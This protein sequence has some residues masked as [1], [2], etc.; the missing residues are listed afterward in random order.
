MSTGVSRRSY[1]KYAGATVVLGAVA[2]ASYGVYEMSKP[3]VTPSP[4][5]TQTPTPTPTP[6][7]MKPSI[8]VYAYATKDVV[9]FWDPSENSAHSNEVVVMNNVYEQLVRY[10]PVQ[11]KYV[12]VLSSG[13]KVSE[14]GL[15]YDF[16]L[17][18]GVKFHCG[19]YFD[20]YSVKYSIERNLKGW[21]GGGP[22]G[23]SYI[24]KLV[25]EISVIDDHT[26][27]FELQYPAA[28]L[29]IA[30]APY[31]A[32]M[33]CPKCTEQ[34][35]HEWFYEGHDLGTGPYV[36]EKW[37]K[38][39]D[40]VT[41]LKFEDYWGGWSGKHFDK[42]VIK[43][44][45]EWAEARLE[46]EAGDADIVDR[47]PFEDIEALEKVQGV[48]V[49][50]TAAYQNMLGF[51]NTKKPP[52]DDKLVRQAISYAVPYQDIVNYA[53]HGNARQSKGPVPYGMWGHGEEVFQ[54]AYDLAKAK[55]LLAK[56]GRP[57]GGFSLLYTYNAGDEYERRS[58]ELLKAELEK[59]GITLELKGM[60]WEEQWALAQAEKPKDRQ[61]IFVMYWWS[62]Y[63]DPYTFLEP[64]FHSEEAI[65]FNLG[66]YSN[67]EYDKLIE[68]GSAIAGKDRVKALSMYIEAQQKLVED[69]PS[70]FFFD[71][72]YV[73]AKRT[74]LRGYVDNP[75]YPDVVFWY[76]CYRE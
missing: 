16:N 17:R 7:L 72:E 55:E 20:A 46:L 56:A 43:S 54:Y 74:T 61:D 37:D 44:V 45:P 53:M 5:T 62:D 23:A 71:Q 10:D 32:H 50:R 73:R 11:D 75:A 69:A 65:V 21:D 40:Q 64:M 41:L 27:R 14:D 2:A 13:W 30:S 47:L 58:G 67:P 28:L 24:W 70:I 33:Y 39:L 29:N 6:T 12:A 60:S 52:L 22:K 76:D 42:V 68:D 4:T 15:T 26:V 63:P 19:H 18:K 48:E 36:V 9:L 25:K 8:G 51:F 35:G 1:L 59:L 57:R 66:Y 31:C 38:E 34:Y 49:V 3:T